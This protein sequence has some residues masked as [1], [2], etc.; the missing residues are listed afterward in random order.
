[1]KFSI[2]KLELFPP[3]QQ[4]VGVVERKQTHEVMNNILFDAGLDFLELTGTDNEVELRT[5]IPLIVTEPGRSTIPARKLFDICRS[6]SDDAKIDFEVNDEKAKVVSGKSRFTL[7]TLPVDEFPVVEPLSEPLEVSLSQ[8]DL[9]KAIK[10]TSFAMAQQD[11][12]YYLNG[13]LLELNNNEL[14]C[15][16]TDG[17]RLALHKTTADV[18]TPEPI[19]AIIP[20]KAINELSRLTDGSDTRIN[21]K[22]TKNHLQISLGSLVMTCKLIDGTF[23]DYEKVIPLAS[24]NKALIDREL[25]MHAL[26]R[27][28]ILAN[29]TYKG[30]RLTL[31]NGILGIQTNNPKREEAEDELQVDY[32]GEPLEIGFNVV[33]LL[34]VLNAIETESAELNVK[35]NTSSMVIHPSGDDSSTYVVMPMRL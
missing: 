18:Q 3:L 23:P 30:V 28:A 6:L 32:T 1:M 24:D 11:V 15:V 13:L 21:L 35:D 7:A 19:S 29:E 17:H 31:E 8:I 2:S 12:R 27:S 25:L 16:S 4:V 33:Y 9:E 5:R 34:D 26:T 14:C 10:R 22:L 20:R